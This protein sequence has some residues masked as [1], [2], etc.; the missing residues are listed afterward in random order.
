MKT[1]VSIL[2]GIVIGILLTIAY[3]TTITSEKI[4]SAVCTPIDTIV[5]VHPVGENFMVFYFNY[6]VNIKEVHEAMLRNGADLYN[7]TLKPFIE[8]KGNIE[9]F[10]NIDDENMLIG[11]VR[12]TKDGPLYNSENGDKYLVIETYDCKNSTFTT[13]KL[14]VSKKQ[15]INA[16]LIGVKKDKEK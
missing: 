5:Y 8:E 11:G 10:Q 15:K 1:T 12:D 3:S 13:D 6:E 14:Y 9:Y 4:D 2:G 7:G 16:C